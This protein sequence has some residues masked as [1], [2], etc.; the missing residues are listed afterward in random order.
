MYIMQKKNNFIPPTHLNPLI[1]SLVIALLSISA[2]CASEHAEAGLPCPCSDGFV[3]CQEANVCMPQGNACPVG[4]TST[5]RST[6][7]PCTRI[8]HSYGQFGDPTVESSKE[9]LYYNN[10]GQESNFDIDNGIDGSINGTGIWQYDDGGHVI[11]YQSTIDGRVDYKDSAIYDRLGR[12]IENSLHYEFVVGDITDRS[13]VYTYS[14]LNVRAVEQ[15]VENGVATR[16]GIDSTQDQLGR[17]IFSSTDLNLDGT[18]EQRA[19]YNYSE[20]PE[21]GGIVTNQHKVVLTIATGETR[22]YDLGKRFD[23][24]GREVAT[25]LSVNNV[26]SL[27]ST[28]EYDD[29][30]RKTLRISYADDGTATSKLYDSEFLYCD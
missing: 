23:G 1:S 6:D 12:R 14:G 27:H 5:A 3:C 16:K 20:Q 22:T 25:S 19:E 28:Q 18:A 2:A 29:R 8:S 15:Q 7:Q 21:A 24:Q 13:T 26:R 17:V 30:G 4:D 9:S 11:L 10:L